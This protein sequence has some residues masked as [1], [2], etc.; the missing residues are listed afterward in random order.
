M[1]MAPQKLDSPSTSRR[2]RYQSAVLLLALA[3]V[4]EFA[5]I[6]ALLALLVALVAGSPLWQ[7]VL[8]GSGG[9]ATTTLLG[10]AV[11]RLLVLRR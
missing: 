11:V 4:A 9:F 1:V 5:A 8:A 2:D 3:L 7:A 6:V 10:L